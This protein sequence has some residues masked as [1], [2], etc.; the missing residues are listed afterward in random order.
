M[1]IVVDEMPKK[2][3]EC[4]CIRCDELFIYSYCGLCGGDCP[5]MNGVGGCGHLVP[6]EEAYDEAMDERRRSES[7]GYW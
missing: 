7:L 1:R 6:I 2:A 5:L 3:E 4:L